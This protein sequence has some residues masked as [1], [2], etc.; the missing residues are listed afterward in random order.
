[1]Q[2]EEELSKQFLNVTFGFFVQLI[3]MQ[4]IQIG[5]GSCIGD[6][7]WLNVC[8]R[9][10]KVRMKIGKCVLVGR[11]SMIST[12]GVLE[13]GDYC[14][15]APRVYVSDADH[16]FTDINQPILQQGA[17]FGRSVIVEENCWLGINVVVTGNLT[18]G[19]CSII[20]ANAVVTGDVPPFSIIAG[21]PAKIIKMY[22]PATK[23][24]ERIKD[25]DHIERILKIRESVGMPNRDEYRN[26]LGK[27]ARIR[28]IDP[29]VAGKGMNL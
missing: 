28:F 7:T 4:N 21:V 29:I 12:G 24:W 22:N 2:T 13:I 25:E 26:I 9:D 19:R 20:A 1:M 14:V 10:D 18:V 11:Q 6:N 8:I 23:E 5:E 3:G 16:V 17:T 27:N 15:L